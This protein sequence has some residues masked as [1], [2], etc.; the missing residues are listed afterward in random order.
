MNI[1]AIE[2]SNLSKT[3][4]GTLAVRDFN[5]P[6]FSISVTGGTLELQSTEDGATSDTVFP[7]PPAIHFDAVSIEEDDLSAYEDGTMRL[8]VWKGMVEGVNATAMNTN[9][10]VY[11]TVS[12]STLKD[13][14][15][16]VD[17]GK[18]T[19]TNE[20][21]GLL[22]NTGCYMSYKKTPSIHSVFAVIGSAQGGGAILGTSGR[23]EG[24]NDGGVMR[25][26]E[27]SNLDSDWTKPIISDRIN[28][29]ISVRTKRSSRFRINGEEAFAVETGFSG[30]YDLVSLTTHENLTGSG[31]GCI[32][33]GRNAG[34]Q[35]IGEFI[36][37]TNELNNVQQARIDAYLMK[38]WFGADT[39]GF[40]PAAASKVTVGEGATLKLFGGAIETGV[41]GGA[42][43]IDGSVTASGTPEVE[44]SVKDDGTLRT[45]LVTG[46]VDFEK[47]GIIRFTGNAENLKPGLYDVIVAD[48]ISN[49][50]KWICE[51]DTGKSV[52]V[53]I[54]G[55][56]MQVSVNNPETLII[57]R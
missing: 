49:Q 20:G 37:F 33:Y 31:L 51:T 56:T 36:A 45:L 13:N 43:T 52:T 11:K 23:Y 57:I 15:P 17:F 9:A 6:D 40:R 21:Y 26:F 8:T 53:R 10:P 50:G 42:G 46:S 3:G 28:Y 19:T 44:I 25:G 39:P 18:M 55:G 48:S 29:A 38:K 22:A 7:Y 47:A 30:A 54:S 12:G 16:V 14:M 32:H 34:G 2:S 1:D 5:N 4:E 35:E 41:I 24:Y 27:N